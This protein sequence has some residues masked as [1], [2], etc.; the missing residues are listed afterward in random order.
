MIWIMLISTYLI[1]ESLNYVK[2]IFQYKVLNDFRNTNNCDRFITENKAIILKNDIIHH[3]KNIP[4][5]IT[6]LFY[7]KTMYKNIPK[8]L[9]YDNMCKTFYYPH[10]T[11][12]STKNTELVDDIIFHF[13]KMENHKFINTDSDEYQ[14]VHS[15]DWCENKIKSW[16]RPILITGIM[17]LIKLYTNNFLKKNG[18]VK[19]SY[20][21]GMNI[22]CRYGTINKQVADIFIHA[23][24]G[25]LVIYRS[26]IK[27][28]KSDNTIIL[29]EIP[30][31]AFGNDVYLPPTIYAMTKILVD[32]LIFSKFT[33]INMMGHSFGCNFVSCLINRFQDDLKNNNIEIDKTILIEGL[34][35]IPRLM[36]IFQYFNENA[37]NTISKIIMG[38]NYGDLFSIP[39]F[40]RDLCLQFY[41]QRCLSF[42]DSVLL[43]MTE[44]EQIDNKIHVIL[45]KEDDKIIINDVIHY[46]DS[47]KYKCVIKIFDERRHGDFAFDD[48]MQEHVIS[49]LY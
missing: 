6:D 27:K 46:L 2:Y 20:P 35:F 44:Y 42:T 45:S 12:L 39:F 15:I 30:G 34:V 19:I 31:I 3:V 14:N 32:Y 26:F 23:S 17:K 49:I 29:L 24:I 25:G 8:K 10:H 48:D 7:K 22:W 18:F 41:M 13:E 9:L 1:L 40:Y 43:G 38:G 4:D 28:L 5:Q 33:K 16:Y 47:K 37:F 36:N 21:N 11:N